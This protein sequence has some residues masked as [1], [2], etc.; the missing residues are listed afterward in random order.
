MRSIKEECLARGVISRLDRELGHYGLRAGRLG[1][2]DRCVRNSS[3][4]GAIAGVAMITS[5][6][7]FTDTF[8]NFG[9]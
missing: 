1:D 4:P 9:Y 6:I 7:G 3:M 2:R 8:S 5:P